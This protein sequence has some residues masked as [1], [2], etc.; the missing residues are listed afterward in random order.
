[1]TI[2]FSQVPKALDGTDFTENGKPVTLFYL[3][4]NAL[5]SDPSKS[6]RGYEQKKAIYALAE[7]ISKGPYVDV[8][9]DELALIKIKVGEFYP[10]GLVGPIDKLLKEL[11]EQDNNASVTALP[12]STR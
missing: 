8:T 5:L 4:S 2:D 1:M 12:T 6:D 9:D 3:A 7:K 10:A 11:P